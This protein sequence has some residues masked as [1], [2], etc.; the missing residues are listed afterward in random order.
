MGDPELKH[1][2]RLYCRLEME[3]E[4]AWR[5]LDRHR[6]S[7]REAVTDD[8]NTHKL[9]HLENLRDMLLVLSLELERR[10]ALAYLTL[11]E[12]D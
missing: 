7:I 4:Q 5:D 1:A 3:T 2:R 10:N 6:D 12:S 9:K 11:M 8:K